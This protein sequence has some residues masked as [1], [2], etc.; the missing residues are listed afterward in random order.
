MPRNPAIARPPSRGSRTA[1]ARVLAT[2]C[3]AH[4]APAGVPCWSVPGEE[5]DHPALCPRRTRAA[6][7]TGVSTPRSMQRRTQ[8]AWS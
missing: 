6:G 8:R 5:R 4:A 2:P 3:Q 1:F 7:Y